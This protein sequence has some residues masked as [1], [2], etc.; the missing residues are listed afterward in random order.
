MRDETQEAETAVMALLAA[1]AAATGSTAPSVVNKVGY[2]ATG[3]VLEKRPPAKKKKREFVT[4][5][6][7]DELSHVEPGKTTSSIS[8]TWTSP[9]S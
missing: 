9:M 6:R 7:W 4:A 8:S 2:R 3:D 1:G 5:F